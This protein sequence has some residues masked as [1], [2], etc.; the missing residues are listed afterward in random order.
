MPIKK[1]SSLFSYSIVALQSYNNVVP[2]K[3]T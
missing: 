3:A 1:N 2:L